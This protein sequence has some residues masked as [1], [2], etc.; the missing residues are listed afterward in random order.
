MHQEE[1]TGKQKFLNKLNNFLSNNSKILIAVSFL[2][3]IAIISIAVSG[4]YKS[5][6]NEE[7]ALA[8]EAIQKEYA[9][10]VSESGKDIP[11][12]KINSIISSLDSLIEK[13]PSFYAGQRAMFMKGDIYFARKDYDKASSAFKSFSEKYPDTYLSPIS[14]YNSAV[15]NEELGKTSEALAIYEDVKEKYSESYPDIPGILFSIG[16]LSEA[17]ENYEKASDSYN[18]IVDN[19]PNSGWTNFARDRIIYLKAADLIK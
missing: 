6:K 18:D 12:D 8:V 11:E 10:L 14:L 19:Y 9:D 15:C 17:S 13:Y 7:S 16:R 5:G 3:V 4:T 2:L 1:V